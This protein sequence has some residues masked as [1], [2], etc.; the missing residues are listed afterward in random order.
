[1]EEYGALGVAISSALRKFAPLHEVRVAH[2]FAAAAEL[3]AAM[4]P[5]LFVLDLD[6]P[7]QGEIE[8]LDQLKT[9]Y[10][11]ARALVIAAGT[12]RELRAERGTAGAIQFIE[13]PFDLSEFGAAVQALLGPWAL[14]PSPAPR[15]TLRD[16]HTLDIVQLKC[17]AASSVAVQVTAAGLAGDIHFQKGQITHAATGDKTGLDALEEILSWPATTSHE[18]ELP[19]GAPHSIEESWDLVLLQVVRRLRRRTRRNPAPPPKPVAPKNGK[20]ILVID[21]TEMLLIFVADSLATANKEFRISTAS[22]GGEGIKLAL[23]SQPDLVLLDYSLTDMTGDVVCRALR[24]DPATATIP[25]LM[26]SGHLSELA[27]TAKNYQNVVATLPKPF[28]SGALI[29]AVEKLLSAGPLPAAPEPKPAP[30]PGPAAP[31]SVKPTPPLPPAAPPPEPPARVET[32]RAP[33]TNGHSSKSPAVATSEVE[34][35]LSI[36]PAVKSEPVADPPPAAL[37]PPAEQIPPPIPARSPAGDVRPTALSV[38]MALQM[39]SM[40]LTSA[41]EIENARLQ[42]FDQIVAVKMGQEKELNGIPLEA[43]FRLGRVSLGANGELETLRLVPTRQPPQLSVPNHSFAIRSSGVEQENARTTL[44]FTGQSGPAMRVRMSA[45]FTLLAVE[46]SLGFEVAALLL[47]ARPGEVLLRNRT[48]ESAR[49]FKLE[50]VELNPDGE[51]TSLSL[52]AS[53]VSR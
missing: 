13:K 27:K 5:E 25:I 22:T 26:M 34:T 38:T 36:S 6:P 11:E 46:L 9:L 14:P 19:P 49:G 21:D 29:N 1:M 8:F 20:K 31:E 4:Q 53:R 39:V 30:I 50:K 23:S 48:G 37:P 17:L 28:L 35:P 52:K 7:P 32:I 24:D 51:L 43:G 42:L 44:H 12:S 45:N 33:S 16:L 3:A 47:Q 40:R 41:F 18:G 2:G 15:G 10:P